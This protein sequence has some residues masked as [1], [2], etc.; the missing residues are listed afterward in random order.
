MKEYFMKMAYCEAKK[1]YKNDEIPVG[2][3][4]VCENEIV[5][6]G[7]N[8][9]ER[10]NNALMHAEIIAIDKACRKLG[11]WRLDNCDIYVTLEP[12]MMCMGA[13]IESRIRNVYYGTKNKNEQMYVLNMI[14]RFVN[15]YNVND[16]DCSKILSDFFI[17]KRKK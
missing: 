13:I 15:L 7:Y 11:S 2:C 3:V 8:K 4:I 16:V 10:K 17:N 5:A 9:K 6:C 1:A 14:N 12:C